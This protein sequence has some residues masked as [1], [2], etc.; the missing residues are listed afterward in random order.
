MTTDRKQTTDRADDRKVDDQESRRQNM[1]QSMYLYNML[2]CAKQCTAK[3][4]PNAKCLMQYTERSIASLVS[5]TAIIMS[6][7]MN[8]LSTTI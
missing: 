5:G 4:R 2:E 8:L 7:I 3:C 1:M 6:I